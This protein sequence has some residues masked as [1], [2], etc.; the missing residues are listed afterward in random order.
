[1]ES[2]HP[3][4][5]AVPS[6]S[7]MSNSLQPPRTI[8]CQ[9]PPSMGFSR[10]EYCSGL[11]FP[12]PGDLSN[13]R[14][15]SASLSS[16]ALAGGFFATVATWEAQRAQSHHS[17]HYLIRSLCDFSAWIRS[18]SFQVIVWQVS[19]RLSPLCQSPQASL[20]HSRG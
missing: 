3:S 20:L 16:P 1:M 17:S 5:H 19:H 13:P 8:A 10:Q 15:K 4:C 6:H 18:F 9:A 2:I 7:I 11:P 12:P 14:I